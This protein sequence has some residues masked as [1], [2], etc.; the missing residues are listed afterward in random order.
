MR[1]TR[2][3]VRKTSMSS[4]SRP[5]RPRQP[6]P[7]N[8]ISTTMVVVD[9]A[10]HRQAGTTLAGATTVVAVPASLAPPP[11]DGTMLPL[12]RTRCSKTVQVRLMPNRSSLTSTRMASRRVVEQPPQ[13]SERPSRWEYHSHPTATHTVKRKLASNLKASRG[14]SSLNTQTRSHMTPTV[15]LMINL[16]RQQVQGDPHHRVK[17]TSSTL[18]L[19][20]R[21]RRKNPQ[22]WGTF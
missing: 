8:S 12:L 6:S 1:K 5:N 2:P 21:P 7:I 16:R 20:T 17:Q 4:L 13:S 22:R 18:M 10:S 15:P 9:P 3:Q 11:A 14:S 19:T